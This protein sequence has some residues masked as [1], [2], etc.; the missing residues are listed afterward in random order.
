MSYVKIETQYYLETGLII[1]VLILRHFIHSI[2]YTKQY[3]IIDYYIRVNMIMRKYIFI[4][5][6]TVVYSL[7]SVVRDHG[8]KYYYYLILLGNRHTI[9]PMHH[10]MLFTTSYYYY[11]TIY[12]DSIWQ[13]QQPLQCIK[14][15]SHSYI[16]AL[17]Y[18]YSFYSY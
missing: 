3:E 15:L 18:S 17:C 10:L 7:Q 8:C 13:Q 12:Y 14:Q 6:T 1:I 5:T 11:N 9:A 16:L 4:Y 2:N